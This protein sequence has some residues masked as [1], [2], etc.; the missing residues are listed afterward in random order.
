MLKGYRTVL[1]LVLQFLIY[2][3]A[4][5]LLVNYVNPQIIVLA[6]TLIALFLRFITDT[7]VGRSN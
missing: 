3:L 6:S 2:A 7:P 1:I 5:P 4:W